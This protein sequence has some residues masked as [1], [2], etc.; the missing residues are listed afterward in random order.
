MT[1]TTHGHDHSA[2]V[3]PVSMYAKNLLALFALMA[4]TIWASTWH[5]NDVPLGPITL[6]ASVISN[7]IAM[8]I[9]VFKALLVISFF[10]HVRYGTT[11]IKLW[12]IVGFAWFPLMFFIIMDYG[13]R[14]YE[15]APAFDADRGSALLREVERRAPVPPAD[16]EPVVRPR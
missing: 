14:K 7:T 11:L 3:F 12:C 16:N 8:A 9:A 5:F 10:M 4:L 1:T 13:T 2:H 15:P 6:N